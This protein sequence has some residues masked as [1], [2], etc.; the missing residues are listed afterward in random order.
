M[1]KDSLALFPEFTLSAHMPGEV[2]FT[3]RLSRIATA[4]LKCGSPVVP[5]LPV[6]PFGHSK[7][8]GHPSVRVGHCNQHESKLSS[9]W[10]TVLTIFLS[11]TTA[12]NVL[13]SSI[14][15][16]PC[17]GEQLAMMTTTTTTCSVLS[18]QQISDKFARNAAGRCP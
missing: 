16:F 15:C 11:G 7:A 18:N 6:I 9:A 2:G 3:L 14:V 10:H 4:K 12:L 8:E 5:P 17:L 1:A 13:C